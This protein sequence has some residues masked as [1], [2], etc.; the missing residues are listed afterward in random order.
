MNTYWPVILS[1]GLVVYAIAMR[2]LQRAVQPLRIE[3]AEKGERL[4]ASNY[5]SRDAKEHVR[6]LLDSA[7]GLRLVLLV[8]L[9]SMPIFAIYYLI[10]PKPLLAM[11]RS[12]QIKDP[13]SKIC[14][15][16]VSALHERI[17][18][19]NHPFLFTGFRTVGSIVML[20]FTLLFILLWGSFQ[21]ISRGDIMVFIEKKLPRRRL[22]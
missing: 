4:L 1:G 22:A 20:I 11:D 13:E 8:C 3:L 12:L 5:L 21:W 2:R 10:Y 7:F 6:F 15:D 16:R 14:F 18:L 9:F 17:T 19:A